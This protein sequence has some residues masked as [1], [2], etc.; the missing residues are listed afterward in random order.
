MVRGNGD[1]LFLTS[2]DAVLSFASSSSSVQ[3]RPKEMMQRRLLGYSRE[4]KRLIR[5]SRTQSR[6]RPS[7]LTTLPMHVVH[8]QSD[9]QL[10]GSVHLSAEADYIIGT[11]AS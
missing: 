8:G 11:D 4:T 9:A 5:R 6:P 7:S 10:V 3:S 1:T 2:G